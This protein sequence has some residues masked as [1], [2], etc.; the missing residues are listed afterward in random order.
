MGE[1]GGGRGGGGII[2]ACFEGVNDAVSISS[3]TGPGYLNY[4]L[5]KIIVLCYQSY[6]DK[7]PP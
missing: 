2:A 4:Q 1:R 6:N 5:T 7:V 3:I